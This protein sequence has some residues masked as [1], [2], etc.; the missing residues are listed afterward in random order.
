MNAVRLSLLSTPCRPLWGLHCRCA[1][2]SSTWA[3]IARWLVGLLLQHGHPPLSHDPAPQQ[4]Q[5]RQVGS[6]RGGP[7]VEEAPAGSPGR[8]G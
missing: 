1:G 4:A 2:A 3:T 6:D 5:R 7:A 8:Q